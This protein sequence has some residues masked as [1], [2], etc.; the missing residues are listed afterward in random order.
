MKTALKQSLRFTVLS[1]LLPGVLLLIQTGCTANSSRASELLRLQ[2]SWQGVQLGEKSDD[3][4]AITITG[5]SLHYHSLNST[6]WWKASFTLPA[7]TTPQQLRATIIAYQQPNDTGTNHIGTVIGTIFK[8]EDET[9]TLAAS[10][11][12]GAEPP[13][14]FPSDSTTSQSPTSCY[15]LKK[16]QPQKNN[17]AL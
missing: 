17:T 3:K 10:G 1:L 2:G 6:S 8:I 7:G 12:G 16:V 4:I 5:N 13:K 15:V 9:L 11:D 14:T